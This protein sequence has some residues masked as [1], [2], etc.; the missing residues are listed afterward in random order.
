MVLALSEDVNCIHKKSKFIFH[1]STNFFIKG[2]S[3]TDAFLES[4]SFLI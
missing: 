3:D 4:I 2:E 1:T